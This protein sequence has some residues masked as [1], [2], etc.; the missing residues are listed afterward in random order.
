M[1]IIVVVQEVFGDDLPQFMVVSHSKP[2]TRMYSDQ[3]HLGPFVYKHEAEV[4]RDEY[5]A[6]LKQKAKREGSIAEG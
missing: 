2:G 4:R 1:E 3:P 6:F 5:E